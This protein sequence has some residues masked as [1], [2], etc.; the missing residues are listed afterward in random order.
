MTAFN[1]P[2]NVASPADTAPADTVAEEL[3]RIKLAFTER[4]DALL[5]ISN[6]DEQENPIILARLLFTAVALP[7]IVGGST[8]FRFRNNADNADNLTI[9]D[10]GDVSIRK[11]LSVAGKY[12]TALTLAHNLLVEAG[13]TVTFRSP[14]TVEDAQAVHKRKNL[15]NVNAAKM[16]DW[17]QGNVQAMTLTA[18]SPIDMQGPA[19][20]GWYVLEI[21]Q[22]GAGSFIVSSWP[23]SIIWAGGA[24]PVLTTTA[25]KTD[26][27]AFYWNGASFIGMVVAQ[28]A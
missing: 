8:S 6:W 11:D 20:G 5:G 9:E 21:K 10:D 23:G 18:H 28:N 14:I 7:Y 2:M 16:I 1:Y 22:G 17:A 13:H 15:G 3:R 19:D 25:G 24:A 26:L 12:L 27:L 4:M